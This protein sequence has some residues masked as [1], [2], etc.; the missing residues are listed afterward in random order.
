MDWQLLL[1]KRLPLS[2]WEAIGKGEFKNEALH[3]N[4]QVQIRVYSNERLFAKPSS[5]DAT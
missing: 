1:T 5:L 3:H 4:I 2:L